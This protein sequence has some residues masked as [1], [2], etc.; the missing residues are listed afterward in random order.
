MSNELSNYKIIL[1]AEQKQA[2]VN[3]RSA[4]RFATDTSLLDTLSEGFCKNQDSVNDLCD[5][6]ASAM[7]NNSK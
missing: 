3:L 4:L 7:D 2:L 6:V 1:S 5:A